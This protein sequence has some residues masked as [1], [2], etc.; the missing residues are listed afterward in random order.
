MK[1]RDIVLV[2]FPFADQSGQKVRP[3]LI[4][5]NDK[6]NQLSDDVIVCAIT[7]TIKPSKYS[8]IINKN[9]L[10]SGILYE[11]SSIKIEN[12]F[13]IKKSLIIK[14]IGTINK[15]LFQRVVD[16]IHN[17]ISPI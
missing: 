9:D 12:I 1:Q 10:E 11:T 16:I 5:S 13:K 4:V 8:I 7:S 17:L 14:P 6:F 3:A 15:I 2:P